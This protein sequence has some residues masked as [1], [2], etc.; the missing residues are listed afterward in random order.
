MR[1][2]V[3]WH[4]VADGAC[5][6][7]AKDL[8]KL[9]NWDTNRPFARE[10]GIPTYFRSTTGLPRKT[11]PLGIEVAAA[12]HSIVFAL[13][14]KSF[15]ADQAWHDALV[16]LNDEFEAAGNAHRLVLV[17]VDRTGL[18][19]RGT[20][21]NRLGLR[22]FDTPKKDRQRT[23]A[24][25]A[26]AQIV[27]MMDRRAPDASTDLKLFISHTKRDPLSLKIAQRVRKLLEREGQPA[28]FFFDAVNIPVG[29][30]IEDEIRNEIPVSTV[31]AV[32]S[33]G[34]AS[35]P[36]CG[37]E[38]LLAK[39]NK[40]PLVVLDVLRDKE[41]RAMPC[42]GNVPVLRVDAGEKGTDATKSR[43]MDVI[44][45][46]VVETMRFHYH[47]RRLAHLQAQG[48]V[49]KDA[50][51]TARPPEDRDI[52]QA[53]NDGLPMV[54][55][56][57][58]PLSIHEVNDLKDN[59]IDLRT[60][61]TV[62]S[63]D[64]AGRV[65]GISVG[66]TEDG[67]ADI[68]LSPTHLRAAMDVVA[69]ALMARGA[70]LAYGGDLR[71]GGFTRF[72]ADLV[73]A[74]DATMRADVPRLRNF[75]P[76]PKYVGSSKAIAS[77]AGVVTVTEVPPP[78]DVVDA[79]L[80]RP[81]KAPRGKN[82]KTCYAKARAMTDMRD[83][84]TAQINA[85]VVLGGKLTG[86]SGRFPGIVEEVD[87]AMQANVPVFVLGGFGGAAQ[88]VAEVLEGDTPTRLS[89]AEIEAADDGY[90]KMLSEYKARHA[91]TPEIADLDAAL[92]RIRTKGISGLNNGLT[93]AE[94]RT[95]F[96]LQDIEEAMWLVLR[97]LAKCP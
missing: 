35:S 86:F 32:R 72:L 29:E 81:D 27:R 26:A 51:P 6:P 73:R 14:E 18:N 44:Q 50:L 88:A 63:G 69:H 20:I 41:A 62:E 13:L 64:L 84:M 79:G 45:A 60:P 65:I 37:L 25:N 83:I 96:A 33:D 52:R 77:L 95:L 46:C 67:L 43:L 80:A 21:T 70:T 36:W 40:R 85:R 28:R 55:Y 78:K 68:G 53:L 3:L 90:R 30:R 47:S 71:E 34:Y 93:N 76:W 61:M 19:L 31:L 66:P 7:L 12:E 8:F 97:G 1:A 11:H 23:L 24:L 48:R 74:H 17:A 58:P 49:P 10:I 94:N 82:G 92:D 38:V 9:L 54:V 39:K 91:A 87:L 42:M 59:G 4:P 22:L 5:R 16:R 15:V 56:P 75:L 2:Y 89:T 57:D